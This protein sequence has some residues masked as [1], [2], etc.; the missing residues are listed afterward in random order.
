MF[1][2]L[3]QNLLHFYN[4]GSQL[5]CLAVLQT[6]LRCI[7]EPKG[8]V[9]WAL[10]VTFRKMRYWGFSQRSSWGSCPRASGSLNLSSKDTV[11][12][13]ELTAAHLAKN[14]ARILSP[15]FRS[16][17]TTARLLTLPATWI[18]S[19]PSETICLQSTYTLPSHLRPGLPTGLFLYP[20]YQI[21]RQH[22]L[23]EVL[24]SHCQTDQ[25]NQ[26]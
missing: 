12:L 11:L 20:S 25:L 9:T 18:Q 24:T 7:F 14:I 6:Q 21:F 5:C 4:E 22:S 13:H 23:S 2:F 10:C 8:T 17:F 26:H 1:P 15:K 3:T 19:T 16:V